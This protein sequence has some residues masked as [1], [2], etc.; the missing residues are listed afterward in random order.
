MKLDTNSFIVVMIGIGVGVD[1]LSMARI[2]SDVGARET[3]G[4]DRARIIEHF[5]DK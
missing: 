3:L 1:H 5:L 2:V 4:K